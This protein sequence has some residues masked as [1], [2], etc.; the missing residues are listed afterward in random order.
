MG[1]SISNLFNNFWSNKEVKI[2]IG[3]LVAAG[4]TTILYMLKLGK[5]I[6]TI[7]TVGNYF[8]LY[9]T[10]FIILNKYSQHF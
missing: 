4:K 2:C 7:P 1:G 3:G 6:A 10:I 9:P 5:V 8:T